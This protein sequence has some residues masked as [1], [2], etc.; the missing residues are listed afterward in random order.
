MNAAEAQAVL[1]R[2]RVT[3]LGHSVRFRALERSMPTGCDILRAEVLVAA[4][5][6]NRYP[7]NM[8]AWI[9]AARKPSPPPRRVGCLHPASAHRNVSTRV[10]C[11]ACGSVLAT[12]GG[13]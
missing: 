1:D 6:P 9:A 10:E 7:A 5:F 12:K 13:W 3:L 2:L 8:P 4:V 11:G